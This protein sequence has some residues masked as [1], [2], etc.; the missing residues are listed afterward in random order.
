VIQLDFRLQQGGFTLELEADL[1]E[2][3]TVLFGPSGAGKTTILEAI[4]GLRQPLSGVIA[5]HGRR[6]FDA[7][8]RIDLPPHQR[9]V[10]YVSQDVSLFPHLNVRRNVLYGRRH[11]GKLTLDAVAAMLEIGALLD[12]GVTGLSGGEKQRVALARALMSAPEILLLDEPLAAVDLELRRRI[13]PY[14]ERVRDEVGVPI[15][16]VTHD[17]DEARRFGDRIVVLDRGRAVW[18]GPAEGFPAAPAP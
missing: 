7:A 12:R 13:L 11:G 15:V 8:A 1:T 3:V 2:R 10:G 16:Y 14:L 6:L 4:A 17:R 9:H 18:T 5:L